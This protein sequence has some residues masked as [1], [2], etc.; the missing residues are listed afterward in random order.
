MVCKLME[1]LGEGKN[2]ST[3][4]YWSSSGTGEVREY[5]YSWLES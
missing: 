2:T 1:E 3:R 5:H 4:G